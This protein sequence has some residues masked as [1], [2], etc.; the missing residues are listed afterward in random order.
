MENLGR[1]TAFLRFAFAVAGEFGFEP[2]GFLKGDL[3]EIGQEAKFCRDGYGP[4]FGDH[5]QHIVAGFSR[6]K[7]Q[8]S[9]L[10]R[11]NFRLSSRL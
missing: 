10:T 5:A 1:R 6:R 3:E 8:L 2:V 7:I 9:W 11:L 4:E